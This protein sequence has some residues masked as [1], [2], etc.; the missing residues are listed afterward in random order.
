MNFF[1]RVHLCCVCT[2]FGTML[3]ICNFFMTWRVHFV[4]KYCFGPSDTMKNFFL[5]SLKLLR[6]LV[7]V[8]FKR[9]AFCSHSKF[10]S[11][12]SHNQHPFFSW[13]IC[14]LIFVM[15]TDFLLEVWIEAVCMC[16]CVCVIGGVHMFMAVGGCGWGACVCVS[17][18]S[19]G[20]I[21]WSGKYNKRES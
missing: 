21:F 20:G 8:T 18:C 17:V 6:P 16:V 11:F 5:V 10:V 2:P 7:T 14:H 9:S 12:I 13:N 4:L 3:S 15:Y 19:G 1:V